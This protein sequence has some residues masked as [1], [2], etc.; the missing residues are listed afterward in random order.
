[1]ELTELALWVGK[2]GVGSEGGVGSGMNGANLRPSFG[3]FTGFWRGCR[4]AAF[5]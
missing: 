5:A 1:M 2:S 3:M 4:D